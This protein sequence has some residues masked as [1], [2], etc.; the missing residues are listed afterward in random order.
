M[1]RFLQILN[2]RIS[3]AWDE[4]SKFR[5]IKCSGD[6]AAIEMSMLTFLGLN[7]RYL[8]ELHDL[9]HN[10][11]Y[12]RVVLSGTFFTLGCVFVVGGPVE[13]WAFLWG[14][15]FICVAAML[16]RKRATTLV[17]RAFAVEG[18]DDFLVPV[19]AM[20]QPWGRVVFLRN[21]QLGFGN[22]IGTLSPPAYHASI[23]WVAL[24][25]LAFVGLT[26]QGGWREGGL[27]TLYGAIGTWILLRHLCEWNPRT[28]YSFFGACAVVHWIYPLV[29]HHQTSI[30]A[31]FAM[32]AVW[33]CIIGICILMMPWIPSLYDKRVSR[34]TITSVPDFRQL[35]LELAGRKL[36]TRRF[37][38][39][40][41]R[42]VEPIECTHGTW[43]PT[44][45]ALARIARRVVIDVSGLNDALSLQ[46]EVSLCRSLKR[47]IIFVCHEERVE[48][49]QPLLNT[50]MQTS[51][52]SLIRW[53]TPFSADDISSGLEILKATR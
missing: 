45:I 23:P 37:I 16:R 43:R 38:S 40:A 1:P 46:W 36:F 30:T 18:V 44:V 28:T 33:Y 4:G 11:T 53:K 5:Q 34:R 42:V 22:G 20:I 51:E 8:Q 3:E 12:T 31:S 7:L 2:R 47:P 29:S 32:F 17:L 13:P 35:L 48:R 41:P 27:S 49:V 24:T 21:R 15:I 19:A 39:H 9:A 52:Y 26:L 50:L 25:A 10:F 6:S 14:G